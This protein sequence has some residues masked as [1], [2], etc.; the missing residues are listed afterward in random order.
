M[1]KTD[2]FLSEDPV[3]QGVYERNIRDLQANQ[4]MYGY[5]DGVVWYQC[6]HSPERAEHLYFADYESCY[7]YTDSSQSWRGLA[8]HP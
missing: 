5:W 8:Q 2:W 7:Q 3:H 4:P 6:A 1:S